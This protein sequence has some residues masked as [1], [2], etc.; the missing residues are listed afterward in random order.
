MLDLKVDR[1]RKLQV[2]QHALQMAKDRR[3]TFQLV[4][5]E[6]FLGQP[7]AQAMAVMEALMRTAQRRAREYSHDRPS[8][9]TTLRSIYGIGSLARSRECHHMVRG[10][11]LLRPS[12]HS[13]H[14]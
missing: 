13:R 6:R 9:A 11:Q 1:G 3:R 14:G 2:N 12:T 10:E 5:K 4:E 8:W 7:V